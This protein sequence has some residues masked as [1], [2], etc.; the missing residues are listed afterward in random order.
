VN[1][2]TQQLFTEYGDFNTWNETAKLGAVFNAAYRINDMNKLVFRN[3]LTRDTDKE[4]RIFGGFQGGISSDIQST[5]LRWIERGLISTGVEG[6]HAIAKF[7]SGLLRWQMTYSS[8]QRD[9]PDLREVFRGIQSSNNLEFLALPASG[10]RFFNKLQDRIFEPMAE[11]SQPFFKGKVSGIFK[12]GFRGTFR[13]R[14]FEARRFRYVPIRSATLNFSLPSNQLFAPGNI[15]PDGF[16]VRELTRATDSYDALM[17]VYAGFGMVDMALGSRWR[18]IGG[19]RIEDANINVT[20]IDPLIP[21]ARPVNSR[22]ANRDALPGVNVIYALTQRQNL[23]F[24]YSKTVSRPDFREL[25]PFDFNNILGGFNVVG[26]PDLKRAKID[27]I[28][29]R[30]EWFPS[31]S[32]VVAASYFFKRFKDPIEIFIDPA[33]ELRQSFLNADSARNQGIELEIRKN[34]GFLGKRMRPFELQGNFTV[35]EIPLELTL[36]RQF[37]LAA[38]H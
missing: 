21:G 3:T 29:A 32:Q 6:E 15:R 28:D 16:E 4:S 27:N 37:R 34:L 36:L 14:D 5:R 35:A 33:Q 30:W 24:G 17:D 31:S 22:L 2:P 8:S 9:E 26:N 38:H 10:L 25:S 1:G 12:F 11:W 13:E 19:V 23:R 20:T 7:R 18:L